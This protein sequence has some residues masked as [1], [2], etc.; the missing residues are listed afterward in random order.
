MPRALW[1]SYG[2]GAVSHERGTPVAA[3]V[4]ISR[5]PLSEAVPHAVP[6]CDALLVPTL[7]ALSPRGGPVQDRV[8]THAFCRSSAPP[9]PVLVVN[10]RGFLHQTGDHVVYSFPLLQ[11][12]EMKGQGDV[13]TC[14]G[15]QQR[16]K[17]LLDVAQIMYDTCGEPLCALD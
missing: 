7:G 6:I 15:G 14:S 2:G 5:P 13:V 17:H 10:S 9:L 4:H 11:G 3:V 12:L 16:S 8:F 1:W